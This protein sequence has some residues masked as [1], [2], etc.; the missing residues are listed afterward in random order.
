MFRSALSI[1]SV[2]CVRSAAS[3]PFPCASPRN[4]SCASSSAP[5]LP[6]SSRCRDR[7][8]YRLGEG[9]AGLPSNDK[10]IRPPAAC[11]GPAGVAELADAVDSK[12]TVL[13]DLWVRPP[14]PAPTSIG[15]SLLDWQIGG[16]QALLSLLLSLQRSP[17]TNGSAG[18][19]RAGGIWLSAY[20]DDRPVRIASYRFAW[21]SH[22][23]GVCWGA[24]PLHDRVRLTES[25]AKPAELI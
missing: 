19:C 18:S 24:G 5:M 9:A 2:P 17:R 4:G 21:A 15:K 6:C 10:L 11:C 3:R 25:H 13:T 8:P 16:R 22:A 12:S 20:A 14:P 1:G 7:R 23:L